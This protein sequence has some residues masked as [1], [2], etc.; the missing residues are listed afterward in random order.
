MFRF[1]SIVLCSLPLFVGCGNDGEPMANQSAISSSEK[2]ESQALVNSPTDVVSQFLD[3]V[4][5]GG[6]DSLAQSLLTRKA[7]SEL[8]RIGQ[9]VQPIGSPDASFQVTRAE[10]VPNEPGSA[11]VHS[12]WIEP[13]STG[14]KTTNQVVWAVEQEDRYWRISGL[15][16][17]V[18]ESQTPVVLD[19]ENGDMM[20]Q[21]LAGSQPAKKTEAGGT[22][23]AA[24]GSSVNR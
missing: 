12:L 11:L 9:T 22:K 10:S 8:Q 18:E 23:A 1:F 24:S 2:K 20:A 17:A 15:V 19:F 16:I 5:R 4:R 13:N 14:G 7:Q 6:E 3:E 21:L